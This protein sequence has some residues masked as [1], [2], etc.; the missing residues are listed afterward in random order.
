[1]TAAKKAPAKRKAPAASK[2]PAVIQGIVDVSRDLSKVG[3]AKG[4]KNQQ[5]GYQFRG[6]DD[7]YA[8]LS[9][10]L[11]KQGLVVAPCVEDR[12]TTDYQTKNG[13]ALHNVV[14]RVRYVITSAKDGSSIECI[15]FGEA[16]DMADKA[17][18]KAL[19]AAYK[20][21]ALQTFCIP[22]EGEEDA[23]DVTH[24]TAP[25]TRAEGKPRN[26]APKRSEHFDEVRTAVLVA[27]SEE[28]LDSLARKAKTLTE[29]EQAFVRPLWKA[30]KDIL[31]SR[32]SSAEEG[33]VP[34]TL[35]ATKTGDDMPELLE[36]AFC[37]VGDRAAGK[38]WMVA[39]LSK[40]VWATLRNPADV[41]RLWKS[42]EVA[43]KG[44]GWE[45]DRKKSKL[46]ELG[47]Q[48][49]GAQ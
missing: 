10:L 18:N 32:T 47:E 4:R 15:V 11:A 44:H 31:A 13:S 5:Q 20:Y 9:P 8:A 43:A 49:L 26:Q 23:D 3:I 37:F 48:L 14:L 45:F 27:E 34:T 6:I 30:R 25:R 41:D 38:R 36:G 1:M 22:V 33:L 39:D 46:D 40:D 21:M 29:E 42:L 24:E 16:M 35:L 19:S 12:T 28:E 17:T 2:A 7:V